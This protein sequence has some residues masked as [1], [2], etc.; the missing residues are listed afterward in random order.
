MKGQNG[1][2]NYTFLTRYNKC[3]GLQ[4]NLSQNRYIHVR[5]HQ[6]IYIIHYIGVAIC[7]GGC[8]RL[9]NG[10]GNEKEVVDGGEC[11][12]T[13]CE[14][15]H[16][17]DQRPG[18]GAKPSKLMNSRKHKTIHNMCIFVF[19]SFKLIIIFNHQ[20]IKNS[21]VQIINNKH[22][23]INNIKRRV[24]LGATALSESLIR[25]NNDSCFSQLCYM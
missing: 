19:Q 13:C 6:F 17:L 16:A 5:V 25:G 23:H 9:Q 7:T 1:D 18:L 10:R 4:E 8:K 11:T 12:C 2:E 24:K 20:I 21:R 3:F 15:I 22:T 14:L